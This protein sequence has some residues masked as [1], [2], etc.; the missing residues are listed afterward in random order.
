MCEWDV[1]G[2]L[3]A[4]TDLPVPTAGAGRVKRGGVK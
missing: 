4:V 1:S 3:L 2:G